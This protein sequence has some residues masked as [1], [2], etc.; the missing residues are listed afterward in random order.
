MAVG[1]PALEV[2]LRETPGTATQEA[3]GQQQP[4][5]R[6][7]AQKHQTFSVDLGLTFCPHLSTP[8]RLP[9][10][11]LGE[12]R[13]GLCHHQSPETVFLTRFG[14]HPMLHL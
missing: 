1:T 12:N 9:E 3:A 5:V 14:R 7:G 13:M 10:T 11:R 6:S 2:D 8:P 4:C